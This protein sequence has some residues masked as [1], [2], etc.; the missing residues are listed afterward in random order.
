MVMNG[1]KKMERIKW[2]MIMDKIRE[3]TKTMVIDY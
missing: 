1:A 3:G 2:N